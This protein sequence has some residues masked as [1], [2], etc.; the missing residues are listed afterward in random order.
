ME[1]KEF[2]N[3]EIP[4][5]FLNYGPQFGVIIVSLPYSSEFALEQS[6]P[7]FC[8][9]LLFSAHFLNNPFLWK[10]KLAPFCHRRESEGTRH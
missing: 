2:S 8:F 3:L 10:G 4:S 5:I 1:L 9:P 7:L 6:H